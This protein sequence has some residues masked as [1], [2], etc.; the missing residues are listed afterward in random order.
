MPRS[1]TNRNSKAAAGPKICE[2]SK[3]NC[4][5]TGS[6]GGVSLTNDS[7]KP[8]ES[9]AHGGLRTAYQETI[10]SLLDLHSQEYLAPLGMGPLLPE[11]VKRQPYDSLYVK[12]KAQRD[13]WSG[14]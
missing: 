4:S 14:S 2:P 7:P 13:Y 5:K 8:S 3:P 9:I 6:S 12:L 11:P 1:L 10:T